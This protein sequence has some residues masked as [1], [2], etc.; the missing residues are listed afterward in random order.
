MVVRPLLEQL[1]I[2]DIV[3][4]TES[5]IDNGVFVGIVNNASKEESREAGVFK[6]VVFQKYLEK[7]GITPDQCAH[8]GDGA[9]DM[10]I[11]STVAEPFYF[12]TGVSTGEVPFTRITDMI[13]LKEYL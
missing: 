1:G 4:A 9:N 10:N 7:Q 5:V 6:L 11:F 13:Q 2:V 12:D 3:F 8:V